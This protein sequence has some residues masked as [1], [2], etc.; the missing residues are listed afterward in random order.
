MHHFEW[1]HQTKTKVI[2][3][4][5]SLHQIVDYLLIIFVPRCSLKISPE[6]DTHVLLFFFLVE[7]GVGDGI[8][9]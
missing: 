7:S 5:V 3:C 9:P 1:W 8:R 4:S 6:Y 2:N